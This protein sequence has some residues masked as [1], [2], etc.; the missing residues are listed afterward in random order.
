[1]KKTKIVKLELTEI[2]LNQVIIALEL[3]KDFWHRHK[4]PLVESI[5]QRL[6][7]IKENYNQKHEEE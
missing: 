4:M 6:T 7:A 2:E 3:Y 1:M 5:L